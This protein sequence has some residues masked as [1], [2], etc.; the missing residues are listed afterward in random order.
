M[1]QVFHDGLVLTIVL[2]S[3]LAL[4]GTLIWSWIVRLNDEPWLQKSLSVDEDGPDLT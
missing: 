3:S 1:G 4:A 2:G